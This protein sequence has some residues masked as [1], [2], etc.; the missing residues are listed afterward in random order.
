MNKIDENEK[1][2]E[3]NKRKKK[4]KRKEWVVRKKKRVVIY[5]SELAVDCWFLLK[6]GQKFLGGKFCNW[7]A[8][9]CKVSY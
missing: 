4:K 2:D 3:E 1:D 5:I 9:G 6:I 8:I 7:Y